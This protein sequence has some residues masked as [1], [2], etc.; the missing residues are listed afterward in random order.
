MFPLFLEALDLSF[1][2]VN[3][4][5]DLL[6]VKPSVFEI[7]PDR[8]RVEIENLSCL[9]NGERSSIICKLNHV[10][11]LQLSGRRS[12]VFSSTVSRYSL[13]ILL[14]KSF[15]ESLSV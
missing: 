6:A 14:I 11:H 9:S 13:R 4:R 10:D 3:S 7:L 8:R 15:R 2:D 1:V 12:N 5:L